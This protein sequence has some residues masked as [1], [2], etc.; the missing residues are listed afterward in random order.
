VREEPGLLE[1]RRPARGDRGDDEGRVHEA[2]P[3]PI[4]SRRTPSAWKPAA[5]K[6]AASIATLP[7]TACSAS[8]PSRLTTRGGGTS[9]TRRYAVRARTIAERT[10]TAETDAKARQSGVRP[11]RAGGRSRS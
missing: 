9:R 11:W 1:E 4:P 7:A 3:A 5:R 10:E 8:S 2:R 6:R